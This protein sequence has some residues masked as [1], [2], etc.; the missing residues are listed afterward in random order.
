MDSVTLG[1]GLVNVDIEECVAGTRCSFSTVAG[2]SMGD[3]TDKRR[4]TRRQWLLSHAKQL[5]ML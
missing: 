4:D 1:G 5:L 2:V 3:V